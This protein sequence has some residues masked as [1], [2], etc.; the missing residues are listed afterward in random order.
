[1]DA[2]KIYVR[3]EGRHAGVTEYVSVGQARNG[4]GLSAVAIPKSQHPK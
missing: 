3:C 1:M 4:D 2:E